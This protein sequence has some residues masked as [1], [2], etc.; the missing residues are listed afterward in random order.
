MSM[1]VTEFLSHFPVPEDSLYHKGPAGVTETVAKVRNDNVD[2]RS[3]P[4]IGVLVYS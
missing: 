1:V 3:S 2:I 4:L